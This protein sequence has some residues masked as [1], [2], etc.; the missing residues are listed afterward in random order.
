VY[1][2]E[3][4]RHGGPLGIT[5]AGSEEPFEPVR[6]S[7]LTQGTISCFVLQLILAQHEDYVLCSAQLVWHREPVYHVIYGGS[8]KHL[9][10]YFHYASF[11][12]STTRS[13]TKK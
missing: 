3:L 1:T 5:I 11:K 7:G 8:G 13:E 6:I 9:L 4:A 12:H 2:V 10:T